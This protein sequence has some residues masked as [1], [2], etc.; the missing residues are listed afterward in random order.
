MLPIP[1]PDETPEQFLQDL[2]R[3]LDEEI[4]EIIPS[5]N[6]NQEGL[7]LKKWEEQHKEQKSELELRSITD[8]L[9]EK[10]SWA[11]FAKYYTCSITILIILVVF[12]CLISHLKIHFQLGS[13]MSDFTIGNFYLPDNVLIA[14]I[15]STLG[16][17]LG[18]CFIVLEYY[19]RKDKKR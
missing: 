4:D 17:V 12:L 18:M 6:E 10:T 8:D 16:S 15:T 5:P 19:F 13:L 1:P 9:K 3:D 11:L 14:L 2:F 7:E